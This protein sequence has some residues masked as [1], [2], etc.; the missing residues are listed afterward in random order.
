MTKRGYCVTK[1]KNKPL[2]FKVKVEA[3]IVTADLQDDL[4]YT[5]KNAFNKLLETAVS[6]DTLIFEDL[7]DACDTLEDLYNLIKFC[8]DNE[9]E[10]T[11]SNPEDMEFLKVAK[12][13]V[14]CYISDFVVSQADKAKAKDTKRGRKYKDFLD[15]FQEVYTRLR[16]NELTIDEA[17]TELNIGRT[18]LKAKIELFES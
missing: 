16:A 3:D 11:S 14:I 7:R 2:E 17:A 12:S 13:I 6:G 1:R 15:N 4:G 10:L 8:E 5:K 18:K 9:I